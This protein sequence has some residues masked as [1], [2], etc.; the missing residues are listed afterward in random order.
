MTVEVR[1]QDGH[2]DVYV[3][4]S[5]HSHHFLKSRALEEARRVARDRGLDLR[6]QRGDGTFQETT[7]Y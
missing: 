6:V 4:G 7:S 3:H 5:H 1:S 2:W